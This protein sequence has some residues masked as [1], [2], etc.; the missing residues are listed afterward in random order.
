M[1][2]WLLGHPQENCV[3]FLNHPPERL[4][5][6]DHLCPPSAGVLPLAPCFHSLFCISLSNLC[7]CD[8]ALTVLEVPEPRSGEACEYLHWHEYVVSHSLLSEVPG[9]SPNRANDQRKD[10]GN[11]HSFQIFVCLF[12]FLL[13]VFMG[14]FMWVGACAG[15]SV[16][17]E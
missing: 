3:K 7:W 12:A 13:W 15:I 17:Y 6:R 1:G 11:G 9:T 8:R 4:A 5:A 10:C 2:S 14:V 16:L